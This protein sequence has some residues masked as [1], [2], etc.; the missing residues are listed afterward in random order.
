MGY[1]YVLFDLDGTLLD[2]SEGLIKSIRHTTA[3]MGL[4]DVLANDLY[5]FIGPPFRQKV[6]SYF[7]LSDQ[8]ADKATAVFRD[9][10][11]SRHLMEARIY[12]GLVML[13]DKLLSN[14]VMMAIATY[15]R[16]DYAA[17]LIERFGLDRYCDCYYGSDDLTRTT[18]SAIINVCL[19]HMRIPDLA[20]AVYIGDTIHDAG[21]ACEAGIDF[22]GVTYG[23]GFTKES[24]KTD[25]S[26]R[27]VS[28]ASEL[29]RYLLIE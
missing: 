4:P 11:K 12:D 24:G 26:M 2:T 28:N 7:S 5:G 16:H 19:S 15:K 29:M 13:L 20:E 6:Q 22:I 9:V 1:K 23:F 8:D 3:A 10:Y 21:G 17:L 14:D 18:K 27:L 25:P